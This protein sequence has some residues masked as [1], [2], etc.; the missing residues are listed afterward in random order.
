[1]KLHEYQAKG[2]F[3]DYGVSVPDGIVA[4]TVDAAVDAARRL[5][6]END[7]TLFIVKAQIHAGGRGKGGG[8][9]L[10]HSVEEVREHAD[11]ILGMDLVTHQTGP[12]GQTVRKIL[13]TEGVDIDQEYYL[14]VTLDRETSMNAIM[15]STEGGV[16]IETVA[17]ESPEK[18]QRVW[19]DPS[20]GLRP[21][22]T[23]Q[24]AFAMGLEGDAFKQAVASIQGLYEAFEEN[25]C[26]LAEINPL[27]QTP[28][29]DIEAVD[30][31]VN[32][33]DNAL[34]RHPD[35]EEM[36]DLHE[37]DPTE[38]KAGEH[39]LSYITLDGNVGCMVNGAG[40]AMA[41]M[42]IIKLAGGEPAN[43][44]DVGGAASAETVEAGFR[45][46]LEDPNVEAL[47]LN[48]FGGIVR[49][50]RVA[51]GVIE[52]AKNIDID[53]PLIVR[54]QGTNAEEGKRLL[55]ESDLSLRSAVLLKEAADEVTAALGED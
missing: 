43:F 31:K 36:R 15:V 39:G 10:A 41:T 29:G 30:A 46:I 38:V 23:R 24:L 1:M 48:I 49:C 45:I 28:G 40:L 21:F 51:Q 19:V 32:L 17:E 26:T 50:D 53:V 34:F 27:V 55:D 2:L 37:E 12:E 14:G 20:I 6:E 5:E 42:D 35:L 8:V 4:E 16:D 3:R 11:N 54:L 47:L 22:Q 18:I 33:D 44:L 25:D 13:V 7:A 52:A 9:K